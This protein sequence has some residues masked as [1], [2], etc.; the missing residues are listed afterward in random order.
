MIARFL[1]L[2]FYK[3]LTFRGRDCPLARYIWDR[4]IP[5]R[6][7]VFLWL[8]LKDRH[9]TRNNMIRKH[10]TR[11]VTHNGCD[12][13]PTAET[14]HHILLRCKLAQTV[15]AKAGLLDLA[16]S[17]ESTADFLASDIAKEAHGA[18]W[19][20]FFAAAAVALW[21]ARNEQ[22]FHNKCWTARRVLFEVAD[23]IKLWTLQASEGNV[24]DRLSSWADVMVR[25]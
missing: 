23:L 7:R 11:L 15:W 1:R 8:A 19:H 4:I 21:H 24:R 13:C 18:V 5:K 2:F 20:V 3:M 12:L 9:N 6:H 10:W 22:V 25:E 16:V 17:C 14:M